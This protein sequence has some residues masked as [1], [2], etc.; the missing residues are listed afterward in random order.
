[1]DAKRTKI[2]VTMRPNV[3]LESGPLK[4]YNNTLSAMGR[5]QKISENIATKLYE[6]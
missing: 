4:K 2:G 3:R 5:K 1:M 6:V